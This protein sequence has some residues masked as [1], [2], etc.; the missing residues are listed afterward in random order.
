[1]FNNLLVLLDGSDQSVHVVDLAR[2]VA[3]PGTATVHLLCAVDQSYALPLYCDGGVA[4]DGLIYPCAHTQTSFALSVLQVATAQ[5][6]DRDF[7]I[8]QHLRPGDPAEVVI[9]QARRLNTE[10]I[11]MGHRRLSLIRRWVNPP[12]S[13]K[14]IEESP[15]A[16]LIETR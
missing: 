11:L 14:I 5:L 7:K 8:E 12:I 15:C 9:E 2:R 3:A 4:L 13:R 10:V 6:A 16:V 1:M